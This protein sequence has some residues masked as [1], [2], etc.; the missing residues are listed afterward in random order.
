M[1][2]ANT[3]PQIFPY[4]WKHS[5]SKSKKPC[6]KEFKNEFRAQWRR[7]CWRLVVGRSISKMMLRAAS[8]APF[9]GSTVENT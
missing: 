5:V 7:R 3:H 8:G 1:V 2:R 9:P 6:G 4:F